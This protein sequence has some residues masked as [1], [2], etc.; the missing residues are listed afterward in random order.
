MFMAAGRR[1]KQLK[2]QSQMIFM[3]GAMAFLQTGL[4]G[5]FT[6]LYL[7]SA[8]EQQMGQRALY[9][10]KT[11]AAM[12]EIISAVEQR[13]SAALVPITRKVA[14]ETQARFVVIGDKNGIRLAHP[15]PERV[16]RSMLDDDEDD[17]A[18]ALS[19]GRDMISRADGNLG[20]TMRGK[21]PI[22]DASGERIIGI[23]SVGL[24]L[25]TVFST[26]AFYRNTIV[27]VIVL[28]LI[29]SVFIAILFAKHFKQAILGLEPVEIAHLYKERNAT[30]ESIR[31]GIIAIDINGR[32]TTFNRAAI[33]TLQLESHGHLL[34]RPIQDVLPGNYMLDV[35]K[36]GIPQ[37]D[38]EAMIGAHTLIVNRLPLL[39]SNGRVFGV[40]SSF[41]RKDELDFV[42]AQLT[43]IQQYA[44]VL[45][46][47]SHE[48]SNK[49][50]TI[51]GLIEIGAADD[52]LKLIGQ[53]NR[54]H[55]QLIQMLLESV[56]DPVIAGCI[57][58]K[59]NR[60]RELGLIMEVDENSRMID[61]PAAIP[62]EKLVS[63][64]GNI[65]DNALE[66]TLNAV[67]NGGKITL[68]MTDLGHDL[69][70]EVEDQGPGLSTDQKQT[71]FAK[72]HSSKAEQGHGYGLHL[73][74]QFVM[75]LHG[76]I[77]I[78]NADIGGSRFSIYIPKNM[79][80]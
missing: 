26:I 79:R 74:R 34:G 64:L 8:L 58:G 42:S 19:Y 40:V 48:Y 33:H 60:A 32:I 1:F 67:G 2:L 22:Y 71:I 30:L 57:L 61:I 63:I 13:D 69:I 49:L 50:H 37:Y 38:Q 29:I 46:S 41:R 76:S 12:P 43:R 35:L 11:V 70:F 15:I 44:E 23:V 31:E 16:G 47:Q 66:A 51:A 25:D 18:Q 77:S 53:E 27:A 52:A 78:E 28:S 9:V 80:V 45:R 65:I 55:Q 62:R 59:Y 54:D 7:S 3:L 6:V 68:S 21:T 72:G 75:Q 17:N 36:S 56:P 10:A 20:A 5:G 24:L 39:S 73:V 14:A 4:V